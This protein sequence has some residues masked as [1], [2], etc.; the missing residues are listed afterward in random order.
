MS[1]T[2]QLRNEHEGIKMMFNILEQMYQRFETTGDLNTDH[3]EDVLR[4]LRVFVDKCHRAKEEELL[5]P[6]L[7]AA[8]I[9]EDGPIGTMRYEHEVGKNHATIMSEAR[10]RYKR[11]DASWSKDLVRSA[12]I[13]IL[14]FRYHI[15]KE[16]NLIFL[17]ADRL[18]SPE[19]QEGLLKGFRKIE[20]E[21]IG[22]GKHREF[23]ALLKRLSGIYLD[24][25][26]WSTS[27]SGSV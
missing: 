21:Q 15:E 18:L 8:G 17:P 14:L 22:V 2:Q 23:H 12:Q 1:A 27:K 25:W 11:G 10:V 9:P 19:E 16:N 6:A 5:F 3:F 13:Y 4:F 26:D 7:I 20:A 24:G